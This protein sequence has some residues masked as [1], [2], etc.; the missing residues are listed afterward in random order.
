LEEILNCYGVPKVN[1]AAGWG[2]GNYKAVRKY[3]LAKRHLCETLGTFKSARDKN[4][5][6]EFEFDY[7]LFAQYLRT[8]KAT[9][10]TPPDVL[11]IGHGAF[12]RKEYARLKNREQVM[13]AWRS[14]QDDYEYMA[15]NVLGECIGKIFVM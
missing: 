7:E 8:G 13:D 10:N 5:R 15:E 14:M 4:L 9:L 6:E 12:G 3:S 11:L 1:R 2:E